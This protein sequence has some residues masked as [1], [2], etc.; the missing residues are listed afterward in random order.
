MI[1][2]KYSKQSNARIKRIAVAGSSITVIT[3]ALQSLGQLTVRDILVA[4]ALITVG[5][6][7]IGRAVIK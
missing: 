6:F 1:L 7:Y 5:Y 4:T 2:R 3:I